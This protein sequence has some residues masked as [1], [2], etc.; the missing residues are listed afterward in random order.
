ME[1]DKEFSGYQADVDKIFAIIDTKL[2]ETKA[3]FKTGKKEKPFT[4]TNYQL[5]CEYGY[6]SRIILSHF[7]AT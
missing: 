1:E 4:L 5:I 6:T 7:Y 3:K 2:T